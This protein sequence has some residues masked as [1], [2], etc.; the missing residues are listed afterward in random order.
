MKNLK[1]DLVRSPL[2]YNGNK[3]NIAD[4]ILK[5]IDG[6]YNCWLEPFGGTGIIGLNSKSKKVIINDID[7]KLIEL[8]KYIKKINEN[9]FKKIL[10]L[11]EKYKLTSDLNSLNKS[12]INNGNNG[13]SK[14]NKKGYLK[15]RDDFLNKGEIQKLF[16]L[17]NYSFNRMIRFNN[18]GKFNVPVGKGDWSKKQ[19]EYTIQYSK[20][21]NE[22]KV[23]FLNLDFK[24]SIKN[25][26]SKSTL[27]YL[28]PPYLNGIA[29]YNKKWNH[30]LEKE[31]Y[32]FL[33]KL[34]EKGYKFALS[35][36][37]FLNG[38]KNELL[39]QFSKK[40]KI[41]FINKK[42]NKTSYNK[43]ER[44]DAKEILVTNF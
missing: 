22:K 26:D 19:K 15:L 33:E 21:L 30:I 32:V 31:L 14:L 29:Q 20:K 41:H 5:K 35:N 37:I 10:N 18:E 36:T 25:L 27:I 40:F 4:Q 42:Y 3:F 11:T 38:K 23:K 2:H 16:L 9:E 12:R 13:Y 24:K 44:Y 1:K 17:L 39:N 8:L 6:E 7:F 43:K 28:D 34:N